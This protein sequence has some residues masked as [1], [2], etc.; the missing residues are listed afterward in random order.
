[1]ATLLNKDFEGIKSKL[2]RSLKDTLSRDV[3]TP[4]G[5]RH[6]HCEVHIP[7]HQIIPDEDA[8]N[9]ATACV[10]YVVNCPSEKRHTVRIKF[11]HDQFGKFL[12]ETMTYV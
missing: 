9:T 10:L 11:Q 1:M 2:A 4:P 8:I 6:I 12:L 3:T 5:E 7:Y